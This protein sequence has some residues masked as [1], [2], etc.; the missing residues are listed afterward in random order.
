MM[1]LSRALM[2]VAVLLLAGAVALSSAP[3][4]AEAPSPAQTYDG[5]WSG[6][7]S[8][9]QPLA[10]T[11]AGNAVTTISS[12]F[13]LGSCSATTTVTTTL[14]I[15]G[16]SFNGS[17]YNQ[18]ISGTFISATSAA[19]TGY[20]ISSSPGCLD[21]VTVSWSATR[22]AP[23]T[24]TLS[25]TVRDSAGAPLAGA[26]VTAT[27]TGG[28]SPATALSAADGTYTLSLA[29]G[30]Y[31]VQASKQ[32]YQTSAVASA[33]VPPSSSLADLILIPLPEA[34]A[35]GKV[36]LPML[37]RPSDAPAPTPVPSPSPEP[38][39][40]P[41]PGPSPLITS[42]DL[43]TRTEDVNNKCRVADA[44][45]SPV[46]LPAGTTSIAY[47][48]TVKV[49]EAR[50][51]RVEIS[52]SIGGGGTKGTSCDNYTVISGSL[53]KNQIG[54]QVSRLDGQPIPAGSYKLLI[55]VNGATTEV[56]FTVP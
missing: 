23:S 31:S 20:F 4:R 3:A 8:Q 40:E 25:G 39:P 14:P 24:Y 21:T 53:Y 32:G 28:G 41:E 52:P 15:I 33:T 42:I 45:P 46:T 38:S 54:A 6:T 49:P 22:A 13:L 43:G 5:T 29:E 1:H 37:A 7:T 18:G 48:F 36:Y 16:D 35:P 47:Q 9:N 44:Q 19:G 17:L 26:Q 51:A 50:T 56:P 2:I 34:V 12:K 30:S 27:P 10:F 11:V 55:T